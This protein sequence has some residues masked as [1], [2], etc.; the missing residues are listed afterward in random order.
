MSSA[1]S[2][3]T[4]ARP[5]TLDEPAAP[6]SRWP[7]RL[8][9]LL[10]PLLAYVVS[11]V[12]YTVAAAL[13]SVAYLPVMGRVR[14]DSGLYA[15][16][17]SD[18]YQ[19]FLCDDHPELGPMFEPGAWCGNAGWFPLYPGL[20]RAVSWPTGLDE[21]AAGL[22]I[23]EVCLLATFVLLWRLLRQAGTA[24]PVAVAVLALATL[25][26]SGIYLRAVFPMAL[27]AALLLGCV[28]A[29]RSRRW[30]WAGATGALVAAAYPMGVA[31]AAIGFGTV[32]TL[33]GR[34][35]LRPLAALRAALLVCA[36]PLV[37]LVAVAAVHRLTV[38]HW[39][40]YLMIQEHYGN[41]IHN[42]L[43]SL[44][45]LVVDPSV[46]PIAKPPHHL[47]WV[48]HVF[49]D[50]ELWWSLAL[51]LLAVA[52]AIIASAAGRLQ[53]HEAGL[54]LFAVAMFVGPLVAGPAVSQ[55]RSHTLMLPV[56]LVLRHLPTRLL[57]PYTL[58]AGVI[59]VPMGMLFATWLLF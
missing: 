12:L 24:R 59:A 54:A 2:V 31:V 49:T 44:A 38:G 7:R 21:Y 11:H 30:L 17:A 46:I 6:P 18:G 42:P 4:P 50:A 26:P 28:V 40:A 58:I 34:R 45:T 41:G 13:V 15:L 43:T 27:A 20:I 37:G 22:L 3:V 8:E 51:V 47:R 29:L 36:L 16:V 14:A 10:P 23:T 39:D 33:L 32:V 57:W 35:E 1:V 5:D 9:T 55:Y 56:L 53:A 52:A 19:L 48:L 25:F